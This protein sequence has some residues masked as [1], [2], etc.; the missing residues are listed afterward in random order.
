MSRENYV[1][2]LIELAKSLKQHVLQNWCMLLAGDGPEKIELLKQ[3]KAN[4]LSENVKVLGFLDGATLFK[5]RKKC[6]VNLCLMGGFSLIEAC[7]SGRP[8]IA[9]DVEW[10]SELIENGQSG[11]LVEEGNISNLKA[12]IVRLFNEPNL[13]KKI[14]GKG[15]HIAEKKHSLVNANKAKISAYQKLYEKDKGN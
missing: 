7:L 9:Y 11:F 2:D 15:K 10:H 4:N 3:I 1:Y 12:A 14:G 5:L 8:T 13:A 6:D